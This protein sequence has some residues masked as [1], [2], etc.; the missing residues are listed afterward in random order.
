M[1][2]SVS[3]ENTSSKAALETYDFAIIIDESTFLGE[4]L[5]HCLNFSGSVEPV[6]L[7]KDFEHAGRV[8]ET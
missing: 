7:R 1:V 8:K 2:T 6:S 5:L 3:F 4:I